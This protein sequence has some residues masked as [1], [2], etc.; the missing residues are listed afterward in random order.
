MKKKIIEKKVSIELCE[1]PIPIDYSEIPEITG[2]DYQ[3]RIETLWEMPQSQKYSTIIIYGDREH[4]SNITYFTG[5]DP[6]FEEA[7]LV[8][9]RGERPAMLVGNEG[10]GYA[11]KIPYDIELILYQTF[12][13]MGQPNDNSETLEK[14]LKEKVGKDNTWIGLIGWKSYKE[15]LFDLDVCVTD[16][17]NYIVETLAA[18]VGRNI[19]DNAT[20]LL[21]DSGYG[22][23]HH[24]S[25]KEIVQ[26]EVQ[27]T[28][29]SRGVYH[30]LKNLKEGM[31]EIEASA[32]LEIDGEPECTHPNV[33]FGD[34]NVSLGLS[35][36]TYSSKL[37]YGKSAGVGYGL[38][39]SLVH[40]SGMYIRDL[41][42]LPE[43]KKA[44]VEEV[45]K[46]YFASVVN[47]YEMMKIGTT[48]GE[49][50]DMVE[51]DLGFKKFNIILNPGHLIH[52]DEWTNSPFEKGNNLQIHSGLVLQCDY[53][54]CF[55][56]PYMP[57]HIEDG[58]AIGNEPLQKEI[59]K[60]SPSCY[61]RIMKRKKF[62]K[63]VLN[64][65][66]PEEVLPLSDLPGVCFPYMADVSTVLAVE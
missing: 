53:S 7:L 26:F 34:E 39:G 2:D 32:L 6:R 31:T 11:R 48:Y 24:V 60:I 51:N 22:L 14:I 13:L 37:E 40:K 29:I 9:K 64:I 5:Y 43:D 33:N 38:R 63:E 56:D 50:Y 19:I 27:G 35:S 23:R 1:N 28:K 12:G 17:P 54:V 52:T 15:E 16:V 10:M 30:T 18:V 21:M 47:W 59:E 8:L 58:L 62:M 57:C 61:Q 4:F 41:S 36:T 45:A 44:F 3:K 46:P 66:L 65:N 42:D 49:V 25:A 20:D 55:D